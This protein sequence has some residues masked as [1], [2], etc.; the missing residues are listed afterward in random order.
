[1][2]KTVLSKVAGKVPANPAS[3]LEAFNMLVKAH[4]DYKITAETERTKRSAIEAWRQVQVGNL[5]MQKELLQSYLSQTFAE[6]RH[7]IDEMFDRL[8]QGIES[9]NT[10]LMNMAMSSIVNIVQ[11]SPLKD[12]QVIMQSIAD[13]NVQRIEF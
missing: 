4:H 10:D 2:S 7:V 11:T 8:D 5:Q 13:P 1:M 3:A 6:R 12:A 9:G